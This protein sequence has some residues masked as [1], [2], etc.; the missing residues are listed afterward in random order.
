MARP[1]RGG[2]ADERL[3]SAP[4]PLGD[5]LEQV[6]VGESTASARRAVCGLRKV[7]E[8]NTYQKSG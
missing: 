5:K 8:G 7:G 1:G 2:E 6:A 4:I 3:S